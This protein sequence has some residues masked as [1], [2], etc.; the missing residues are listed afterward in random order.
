MLAI[1]G[2]ERRLITRAS[3]D[4]ALVQDRQGRG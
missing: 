4:D 1:Q 2:F 3:A